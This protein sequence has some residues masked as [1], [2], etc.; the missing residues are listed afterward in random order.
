MRIGFRF[1]IVGLA[2]LASGGLAGIATAQS[3]SEDSVTGFGAVQEQ[4]CVILTPPYVQC[5]VPDNYYFDA[6]SDPAGENPRGWVIF[7]TGERLGLRQDFGSVTCLAVD[8]NK[9]SIGVNFSGFDFDAPHA[10]VVFVEDNGG[11]G[12]DRLGVQDLPAG[13]SAPS[14]CPPSSSAGVS[15][16]P[17]YP[18]EFGTDDVTVTDAVAFP[19]SKDQCKNN[20]WSKYGD[21]TNQGECVRFVREKARQKCLFERAAHGVAAFRAKYGSGVPKRHAWGNCIKL[22]MLG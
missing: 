7:N 2:L 14:V 11:A 12:D 17:T 16:E 21:F 9:A 4:V 20:G 22:R 5:L 18:I 6:H 1:A 15:L 3:P 10:A 13:S 8:G 19:T